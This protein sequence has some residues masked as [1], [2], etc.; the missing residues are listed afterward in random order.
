M[1]LY[2]IIGI[3]RD[4]LAHLLAKYQWDQVYETKFIR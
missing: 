3:L 4:F 2:G 1:P